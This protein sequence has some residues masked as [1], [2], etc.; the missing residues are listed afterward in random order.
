MAQARIRSS[1]AAGALLAA[2]LWPLAAQALDISGTW[3]GMGLSGGTTHTRRVIQIAKAPDGKLLGRYFDLGDPKH[4][5][6]AEPNADIFS[7]VAVR[8]GHIRFDLDR[9]LGTFEGNIAPDGNSLTGT[10]SGFDPPQAVSFTRATAKTQWTIDASPHTSRFI[11]VA[12]DVQLEVLDWG[13]NGPPLL[14]L[15]GWGNTAHVFDSFAPRF[16]GKHHVY[17]ITRRGFGIS[18]APLPTLENYDADR[19]ADDV[20]AVIAALKLDGPVLAGHSVAGQ[21]MSSIGTRHPERVRGL[22]YLDAS[23]SFAFYNPKGGYTIQNEVDSMRR[24]LEQLPRGYAETPQAIKDVLNDLPRLKESLERDL[25]TVETFPP[26]PP[27]KR[28]T[29]QDQIGDAM[30]RSR[31]NY[32]GIKP[33]FLALV[34]VPPTCAPDCNAPWQKAWAREVTAQA[35]VLEADYPKA[36]IRRLPYADHY[37]FQSNE[38]EVEHEMNVFLDGLRR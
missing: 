15:S 36:R 22:I 20:L 1:L 10:W 9:L 34:A 29:L 23:L 5:E 14:F 38:A 16:T 6:N 31:H 28:L 24:K 17:G 27:R 25:A 26:L 37:V 30:A 2:L 35:N 11:T 7:A 12:K 18:S 19:L 3:Q 13:G 4:P 33:P 32:T 21:E 8:G